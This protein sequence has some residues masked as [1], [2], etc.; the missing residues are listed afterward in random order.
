MTPKP[1]PAGRCRSGL[2]LMR[3]GWC[4]GV[5]C[6]RAVWPSVRSSLNMILC[7]LCRMVHLDRA[8]I[9]F[10]ARP[11]PNEGRAPDRPD[12]LALSE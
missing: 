4:A 5:E 8:A 9:W 1:F 7:G 2:M 10:A 6:V 11:L 3:L 12:E